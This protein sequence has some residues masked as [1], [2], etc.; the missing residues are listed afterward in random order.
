[1]FLFAKMPNGGTLNNN[2]HKL[3]NRVI[4]KQ[5]AQRTTLV[6]CTNS[7]LKGKESK[8]EQREQM[9]GN[10]KNRH[11][12][13]QQRHVE[14]GLVAEAVEPQDAASAFLLEQPDGREVQLR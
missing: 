9:S 4:H 10:R 7:N 14:S 5:P 1:M 8:D 2:L 13:C 12:H 3:R 6:I 11:S